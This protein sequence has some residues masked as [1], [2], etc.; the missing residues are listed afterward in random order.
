VE[1]SSVPLEYVSDVKLPR[2]DSPGL[3]LHLRGFVVED[4]IPALEEYLDTAYL[5]GL[6]WVRIV[7]GKG[8]GKLRDAIRKQLQSHPLVQQ[9]ERAPEKEGGDGVTIVHFVP[10]R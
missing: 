3:E 8:T 6:P 10:M 4:A 1:V 2:P 9:F 5:S 7:H